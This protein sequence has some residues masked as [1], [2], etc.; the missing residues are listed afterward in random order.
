MFSRVF[1]DLK[2]EKGETDCMLPKHARYQLR[3]TPITYR[4]YT[5]KNTFCQDVDEV[6]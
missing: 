1:E 5:P 3:Y 2:N 6:A 4:Y